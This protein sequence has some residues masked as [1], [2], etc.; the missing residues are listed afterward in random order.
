MILKGSPRKGRALF[1]ENVMD[2]IT[3]TTM[4]GTEV[5]INLEHIVSF[6]DE[7]DMTEISLVNQEFIYTKTPISGKLKDH[8][9]I[10]QNY[11]RK[12]GE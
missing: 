3:V 2:F 12:I 4:K 10:M 5:T 8:I 9:R 11:V 6:K 1:K 7:D